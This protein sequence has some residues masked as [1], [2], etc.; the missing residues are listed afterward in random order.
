MIKDIDREILNPMKLMEKAV[1]V[2]DP[3]LKDVFAYE[4]SLTQEF[5]SN[6]PSTN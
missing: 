4:I 6:A 5:S 1:G 2:G 3:P